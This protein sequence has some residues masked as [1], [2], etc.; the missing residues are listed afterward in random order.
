METD[1]LLDSTEPGNTGLRVSS[2][3]RLHRLMTVS[4]SLIVRELGELSSK[5]QA[6]VAGKLRRLFEIP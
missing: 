5:V 1:I 6:L 4:K 2:T 3:L